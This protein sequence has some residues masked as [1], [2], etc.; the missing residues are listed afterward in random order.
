MTR[1][2]VDLGGVRR[3]PYVGTTVT[4]LRQVQDDAVDHTVPVPALLRR[5]LVLAKRLGYAPLAEWAQL[6]LDGY[7]DDAELPEYR[8]WRAANVLG[9]FSG[10]AGASIRNQ[11][12]PSHIVKEEWRRLLF[13][14]ELRQGVAQ[15][16]AVVDSG[17]DS[18]IFPWNQNFVLHYQSKFME[19]FALVTARRIVSVTEIHQILDAVRTRLLNFALELEETAPNAGEA[20][21][22]APVVPV[23]TVA[24]A[25][26]IHIHGDNNVV[27]AAG[28]D[29]QQR[30]A[31][32]DDP[33]WLALSR[34]LTDEV[35]LPEAEL[36]EL[37]RALESDSQRQLPAGAMG[38]DTAKW[39]AGIT[40]KI[41]S[42]AIDV[43]NKAGT[44]VIT[45]VLL[46]FVGAA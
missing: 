25:F 34:A 41:T 14:F 12:L 6:E 35:G 16:Q 36:V 4:L 8:A 1:L 2:A 38:P 7:P 42:G 11:P 3:H 22:G 30:V 23:E 19:H 27:A 29:A 40:E 9:D 17:N 15:Y 44:S 13:G 33:R 5:A 45:Q 32:D 31:L 46:K 21:P 24:N 26:E 39:H 10:Y 28:R 18:L 20:Q 37:H 43:A